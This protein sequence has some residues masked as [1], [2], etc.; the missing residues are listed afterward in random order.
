MNYIK[1]QN[2][3]KWQTYRKDR[4][5]PPWI[6]VH[7]RI[8]LNPEWVELSDSERGQLIA[9]WLLAAD[10][11]GF[12]PASKEIVKKL[13]FM[14]NPPDFNK[15][16]EL[17]FL[18]NERRRN[19][20]G[21]TPERQPSVTPKAKAKAEA[22][23]KADPPDGDFFK[24]KIHPYFK[25]IESSSLAILK[26]PCKNNNKPF[27]PCQ[28]VNQQLNKFGRHPGALSQTLQQLIQYWDTINDPQ[29]YARSI[30]KTID[31]NWWEK[32]HIKDHEK[33]KQEFIQFINKSP[34][35]KA[36]VGGIGE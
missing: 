11:D 6:K 34:E 8:R 35:L 32:E 29:G 15:F 2:W 3:E 21:T 4:G 26:L 12:I 30:L 7:R 10:K 1:I 31:G 17:G 28:F 23:A 16:I 20:A 36:L 24:D 9:I 5:Q 13:C 19:D 33:L 22:K 14:T 18:E 25:E 27:N